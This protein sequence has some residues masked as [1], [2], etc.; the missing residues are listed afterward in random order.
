MS[1]LDLFLPEKTRSFRQLKVAEELRHILSNTLLQGD[2]PPLCKKGEVV[3]QLKQSITITHLDISPDLKQ[4]T[5]YIMPLLGED[6]E[7]VENYFKNM[8]PYFRH[9]VSKKINLRSAPMLHF[10]LDEVFSKSKTIDNLLNLT[11]SSS[12]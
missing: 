8:A 1:K 4:A 3:Y 10:K 5:V 12:S 11:C 2:F 9:Q 7:G 6:T